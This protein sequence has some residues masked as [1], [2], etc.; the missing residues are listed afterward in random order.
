MKQCC[1][2]KIIINKKNGVKNKTKSLGLDNTCKECNKK[3]VKK[4]VELNKEKVI[5]YHKKY[6]KEKSKE[7]S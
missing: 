5:E 2:C 4:W 6:A 7:I 3:R 1:V